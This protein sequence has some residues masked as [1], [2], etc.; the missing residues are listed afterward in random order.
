[1]WIYYI[2]I[3]IY[4]TE[5]DISGKVWNGQDPEPCG[6]MGREREQGN[7][8]AAA[9]RSRVQKSPKCLDYIEKSLLGEGSPGP[10]LK[11]SR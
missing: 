11:S 6:E 9:R 10:G 5:A 2:H 4:I 3:I 7:G 8:G 1:M